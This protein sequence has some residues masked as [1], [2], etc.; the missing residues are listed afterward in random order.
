[1]NKVLKQRYYEIKKAELRRTLT[2]KEYEIQIKKLAK[3]L[4]L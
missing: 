4:G 3:E 2:P 1:M